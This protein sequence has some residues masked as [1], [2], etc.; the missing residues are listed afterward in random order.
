LRLAWRLGLALRRLV[1]PAEQI[2]EEAAGG[3][4][5]LRSGRTGQQQQQRKRGERRDA[6]SM[7]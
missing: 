3:T 1:A 4:L 5:I 6:N 2:I 7:A